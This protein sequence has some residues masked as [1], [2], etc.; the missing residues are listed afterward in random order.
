MIITIDGP[1]GSGKSTAARHLAQA[2]GIAFLDTGAT[3]R[4]TTLRAMRTGADLTDPQA[5]ARTAAEMDLRLVI[6]DGQLRVL[7]DGLDVT[8]EIRS[9]AVSTNAHH[10]ARPP[11]VRAVLVDLQRRMGQD[12]GQFVTEGRDQGTVVFPQAD[13]KIYLTARPEVR[14]QRRV[15]QLRQA[16]EP[17]DFDNVLA[18]IHRR[19]RSDRGRQIGPL[20][21]PPGAALVDTSEMAPDQTLAALL[22]CVEAAR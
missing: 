15:D 3:Y 8:D 1:A 21:V 9:E 7:L 4:A 12:L 6:D 13:V 14:A 10:A 17:A 16:G 5:M 11:Q 19:D 18:A 22:R 20:C 2:L